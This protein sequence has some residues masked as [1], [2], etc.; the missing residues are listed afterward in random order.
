MK[1]AADELEKVRET[2]EEITRIHQD[3]LF[4]LQSAKSE[5]EQLRSEAKAQEEIVSSLKRELLSQVMP[6]GC[7]SLPDK[8]PSSMVEN[9]AKRLADWQSGAKRCDELERALS[10]E[11]AKLSSAKNERESVRQKREELFSRVRAVDAERDSVKQQRVILF[12][13]RNPESERERMSKS[14]ESLR[15]L[16]NERT[17]AKNEK[18]SALGKIQ[19]AVHALET[20]MATGREELQKHEIAFS[21]KM[22]ALGFRNEDD[23]ASA[24][25]TNDE[26]RDLQ[27]KLR[28][29]TRTDFDL[30]TERENTRAKI[31][32]LQA[33]GRGIDSLALTEK[34]KA[35]KAEIDSLNSEAVNDAESAVFREKMSQEVIPALKELILTCGLEEVF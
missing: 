4:A 26:R 21:K 8:N 16:L 3:A 9:L 10:A 30:H 11:S 18:A 6:Y 12:E 33:D 7:K 15:S 29:L 31:L 19:S 25:L 32:E 34:L 28:E 13:S 23:Y 27:N 24:L 17:E 14:V 22:L 2:R 1:A 20:E 5:E 35:L